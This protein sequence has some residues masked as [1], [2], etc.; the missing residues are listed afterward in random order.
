MNA[1]DAIVAAIVSA[2]TVAPALAGGRVADETNFDTVPDTVAEAIE[3]QFLGSDADAVLLSGNPV[4]WQTT[5]RISCFARRDA[6]GS[7]GRASRALHAQVYARLMADPTLAGKAGGIDPPRLRAD[8]DRLDT[9][10][11]VLHADYVVHHN[12]AFESLDA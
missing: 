9:R 1:H 12:T 8:L 2:L 5:V 6:A 7:A 11:G 3:V 4:F 10:V